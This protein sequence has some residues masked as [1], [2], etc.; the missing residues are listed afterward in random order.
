MADPVVSSR[1]GQRPI[2]EVPALEV[3][4]TNKMVGSLQDDN[5]RS[6]PT[7]GRTG[8]TAPQPDYS[9]YNHIPPYPYPNIPSGHAPPIPSYYGINHHAPRHVQTV[10]AYSQYPDTRFYTYG[11]YGEVRGGSVQP[12]YYNPYPGVQSPYYVPPPPPPPP[13]PP[14]PMAHHVTDESFFMEG[15][16]EFGRLVTVHLKRSS[17]DFTGLPDF[18]K[19]ELKATYGKYP[20][21]DIRITSDKG[22][23]HIYAKPRGYA[24]DADYPRAFRTPSKF[25]Q[26][27]HTR[28]YRPRDVE[29]WYDWDPQNRR[30]DD[31][32]FD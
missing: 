2:L 21:T 18:M 22:E 16:L 7:F 19:R 10:P 9:R 17:R 28:S 12:T 25:E 32:H 13:V 20:T 1:F 29:R 3:F 24:D 30:D 15:V 14:P 11:P 23:Y 5:P 27:A 8:Y 31:D 4:N 26:E 6:H